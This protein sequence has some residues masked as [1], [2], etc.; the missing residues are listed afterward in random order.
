MST[1][2]FLSASTLAD[3][4]RDTVVPYLRARRNE[5]VHKTGDGAELL[6]VRYAADEPRGSVVIVHGL[7]ECTEK[8]LE[9]CY[10]FLQEN[11]TVLLYDQRGHGRSTRIP[12]RRVIHVH[13]FSQ[14]VDDLAELLAATAEQLPAP[15]YLFAHSMGGAVSALYLERGTDFFEKAVLSS[16][17]IGVKYRGVP[18]PLVRWMCQGASLLGAGKRK[19][20][21][22]H[23]AREPH[24]EAFAYASGSCEARFDAYQQIKT[25]EPLY[26]NAKPSC[27][28]LGEALGCHG[29]ILKKGAPER[30][31]TEILLFA[32]EKEHLVE[33][34]DQQKFIA[35]VPK[36]KMVTVKDAK[37]EL[38]YAHD[39]ILH[40]YLD[41]ILDFFT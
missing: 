11:L 22:L 1:R 39:A 21:L 10:Y 40:P 28:W 9:M 31:Q 35:R 32:A 6:C 5:W 8:F 14:Y 36:G 33:L 16:P 17:M 34:A 41:Q 3:A 2:E 19:L 13:R 37:H 38:Y 30:I 15:R 7:G 29:K 25:A 24:E 4:L 12:E 18:R 27:A 26:R 20:F 23:N